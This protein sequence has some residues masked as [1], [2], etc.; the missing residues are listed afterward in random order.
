MSKISR[1]LRNATYT[2][3]KCY[4][5]SCSNNYLE[6][7]RIKNLDESSYLYMKGDFEPIIPEEIFRRCE[8]IRKSRTTKMVV[9]Q[10]ERTYGKRASQD[11]WLR[12]LRCKCGSIFRKNKWRT[13]KRGDTVYG[14]Q[15]YNQVN[16]GSK[17]FREKNGLDVDGYC[18]IRM[19]GD[20]K[21]DLMAKMIFK[22]S[23]QTRM[24]LSWKPTGCC[25][26]VTS[27]T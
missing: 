17:T 25:K 12:K 19:I 16:N 14:Y 20:W 21:L 27:P 11:V 23:G 22:P 2:G 15:C 6:Q 26:S 9:N 5:K 13:N 8:E 1:I 3:Y 18:D 10:G 4:Y 24:P 7:K